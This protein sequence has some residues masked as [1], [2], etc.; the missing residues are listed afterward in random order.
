[1]FKY[2]IPVYRIPRGLVFE[3]IE[4][5]NTKESNT[6]VIRGIVI[7]FQIQEERKG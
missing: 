1:M 5:S 7:E 4:S 6:G 2:E 3:M